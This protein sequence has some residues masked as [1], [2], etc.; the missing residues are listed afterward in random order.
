M[1]YRTLE[2]KFLADYEAMELENSELRKRVD[3]LLAEIASGSRNRVL[4]AAV[5]SAGRADVLQKSFCSWRTYS[6]N[7]RD[8]ET[9]VQLSTEGYLPKGV[10][11]KEFID[12]FEE[13]LGDRYERQYAE[14]E[15]E[16]SGK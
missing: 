11:L 14:D 9:W 1:S 12:Y 10:S 5:R 2:E 6:A 15:K 13:E 4:D 3:E 16:G 7:D 8:F